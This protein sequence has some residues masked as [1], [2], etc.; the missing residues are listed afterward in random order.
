MTDSFDSFHWHQ[1]ARDRRLAKLER[2]RT[3]GEELWPEDYETDADIE[4][5][6]DMDDSDVSWRVL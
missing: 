4:E 5:P 3:D 1:R 2:D 6:D